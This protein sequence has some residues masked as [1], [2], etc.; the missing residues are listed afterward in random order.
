MATKQQHEDPEKTVAWEGDKLR[1]A[2]DPND[3][4]AEQKVEDKD[5]SEKWE[6]EK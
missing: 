5:E 2:V 1:K 6:K 4:P 3:S